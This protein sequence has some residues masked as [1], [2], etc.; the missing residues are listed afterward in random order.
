MESWGASGA[1]LCEGG[2]T[3]AQA[4]LMYQGLRG[5]PETLLGPPWSRRVS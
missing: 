4:W 1:P 2:G 5:D 3:G